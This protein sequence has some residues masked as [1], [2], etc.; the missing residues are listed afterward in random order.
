MRTSSKCAALLVLF[1]ERRQRRCRH[2]GFRFLPFRSRGLSFTRVL[3]SLR[4]VADL[5]RAGRGAQLDD[6]ELD[7]LLARPIK[8]R[9]AES[10]DA[11]SQMV[12]E[13]HHITAHASRSHGWGFE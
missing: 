5:Q 12:A 6:A 7:G 1:R 13:R 11:L 2:S 3:S 10:R 8:D 9:K 4:M